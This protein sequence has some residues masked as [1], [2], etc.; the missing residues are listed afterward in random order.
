MIIAENA[1]FLD[2][3]QIAR[4]Q[5]YEL[6]QLSPTLGHRERYAIGAVDMYNSSL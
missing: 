6:A 1:T 5:V 3:L 4:I 2:I